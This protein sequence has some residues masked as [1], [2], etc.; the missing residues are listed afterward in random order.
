V[1]GAAGRSNTNP[2]RRVSPAKLRGLGFR[3]PATF[4]AALEDYARYLAAQFAREGEV[5][6]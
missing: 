5:R 1:L 2:L 3:A 4:E 6:G